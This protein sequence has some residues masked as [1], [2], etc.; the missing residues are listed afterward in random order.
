MRRAAD[1][2]KVGGLEGYQHRDTKTLS[3]GVSLI[4]SQ[5]RV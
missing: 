2:M 1:D 5:G 3:E 4:N